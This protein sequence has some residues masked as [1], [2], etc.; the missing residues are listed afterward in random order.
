M[1][2]TRI[3]GASLALCVAGLAYA[4]PITTINFGTGISGPGISESNN[5]DGTNVATIPAG[6]WASPIGSSVWESIQADSLNP[7]IPDG[8][9]VD[10]SFTFTLEDMPIAGTLGLLVDDS[11][12]V[13]VNGHTVVNNIGSPQGVNCAASQPN[14][15]VP[16]TEDISA[17]L[18]GGVNRVDVIVSQDG[19]YQFGLDVSGTASSTAPEP[20][21]WGCILIGIG[22]IGRKLRRS[23]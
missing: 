2:K 18:V 21:T 6:P 14:C 23:K 13:I 20:A 1:T 19:G 11:A 7:V 4:D 17:D 15:L 8:T 12:D 22:I 5:Y 9:Q 3:A 10:F 16:L